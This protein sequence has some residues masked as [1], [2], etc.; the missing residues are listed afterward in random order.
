MNKLGFAINFASQGAALALVANDGPWSKKVVDSRR[1]VT[2]LAGLENPSSVVTFLSFDATGCFMTL[3]KTISGRSNDY[4]SGWVYIPNTVEITGDQ[5]M[6]VHNYVRQILLTV[7]NLATVRSNI[8]QFFAQELPTKPYAMAYVP[9]QGDLYGVRYVDASTLPQLLG[10]DRYQ[11]V[12]NGFRAIFLIDRSQGISIRPE[13][14]SKFRDLS[15]QPMQHYCVVKTPTDRDVPGVGRGVEVTFALHGQ[16]E[17]PFNAPQWVVAGSQVRIAIKK[18]G[19]QDQSYTYVVT[20]Q[21]V[22]EFPKPQAASSGHGWKKRVNASMFVITDGQGHPVRPNKILVNGIDVMRSDATLSEED[23]RNATVT[24]IAAGY[25]EAQIHVS[26][27]S[28]KVSITLAKKALVIQDH[29]VLA[30]GHIEP[31]TIEAKHMSS[32]YPG[33]ELLEGYTYDREKRAYALNSGFVWK[34]RLLGVVAG[35]VLAVVVVAALG[36]TVFDWFGSNASKDQ[37]TVNVEETQSSA[38]QDSNAKVADYL[39][40]NASWTKSKLTDLGAQDLFKHLNEFDVDG[41]KQDANKYNSPNLQQVVNALNGKTQIQLQGKAEGGTYCKPGDEA[42]N[43][44]NYIDWINKPIEAQQPEPAPAPQVK[45]K[46]EPAAKPAPAHKPAQAAKPAQTT[47]PDRSAKSEKAASSSKKA[48]K[49]NQK[50]AASNPSSA[51]K[52]KDSSKGNA[53]GGN[54]GG[55]TEHKTRGGL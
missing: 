3:L 47:K 45:E 6:Q 21:D 9:S 5:M 15:Q 16:P 31:F 29:I 14:V 46:P 36:Y 4:L 19:Y 13:L 44:R 7:S 48:S 17:H 42:I 27:N 33:E 51:K 39:Q 28:G 50:N 25:E 30:N 34:Q 41:I 18:R 53:G 43:W 12:Y 2:L 49:D 8:M 11:Q 52:S 55:N 22:Q 1:F 32:Y 37:E 38:N 35:I 20:H 10:A 26:L 54:S 24:V 23:C 40:N